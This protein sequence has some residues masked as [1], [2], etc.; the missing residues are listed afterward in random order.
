MS[1]V[2]ASLEIIR[3]DNDQWFIRLCAD[4]REVQRWGPYADELNC[5]FMADMAAEEMRKII[6]QR[7]GHG[8]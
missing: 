2:R 4:D 8:T 7:G 5:L 1:T 3:E 6:T